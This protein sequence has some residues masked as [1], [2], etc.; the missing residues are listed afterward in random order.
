M[1]AV[2]KISRK[3][4]YCYKYMDELQPWT[5]HV[6][7]ILQDLTKNSTAGPAVKIDVDKVKARHSKEIPAEPSGVLYS[8]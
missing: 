1:R 4:E 5:M 3:I 8:A 6:N 7:Q 2:V